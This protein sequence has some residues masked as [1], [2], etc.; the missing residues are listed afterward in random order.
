MRA[1]SPNSLRP[2]KRGGRFKWFFGIFVL[3]FVGGIAVSELLQAK[4]PV[5][6]IISAPRQ[7]FPA[8]SLGG[9]ATE[10]WSE[11]GN[12]SVRFP[13]PQAVVKSPLLVEG[14]ERTF[15]Q[16]VVVRIKDS[17][18]NELAKT[19]VTGTA[20]DAGI[21]GP[22]RAELVFE[23]PA[24]RSGVLEVF[25]IAPQDGSEIDKITVPVRFE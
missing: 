7:D 20:P 18:A 9:Q 15:E 23:K 17:K 2:A 3:G 6:L 14:M 12:L 4:K 21:H 8:E 11:G 24:T 5:E 13:P 19:T 25:Q 1:Y 16:N 22:Y 10:V